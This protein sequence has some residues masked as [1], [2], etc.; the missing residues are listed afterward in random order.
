MAAIF[1]DSH[2][3]GQ[4]LNALIK[5]PSDI[6]LPTVTGYV[7]CICGIF[8]FSNGCR[9]W[10]KAAKDERYDVEWKHPDQDPS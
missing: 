3:H 1:N 7:L 10:W 8:K 6:Y 5:E 2:V 4:N 9:S